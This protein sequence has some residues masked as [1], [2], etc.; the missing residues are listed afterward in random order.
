MGFKVSD[1]QA[2]PAPPPDVGL[3]ENDFFKPCCLVRAVGWPSPPFGWRSL[4]RE[5]RQVRAAP[6]AGGCGSSRRI[7]G[8][9]CGLPSGPCAWPSVTHTCS[10]CCYWTPGEPHL[11]DQ[12]ALVGRGTDVCASPACLHQG[13]SNHVSLHLCAAETWEFRFCLKMMIRYNKTA[14]FQDGLCFC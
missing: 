7:L 1:R 10:F 6:K 11:P 3:K 4:S 13:E 5:V 9:P 12:G 14:T 8:P 2:D